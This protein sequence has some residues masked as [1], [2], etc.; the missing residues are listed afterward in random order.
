M[1]Q[2]LEFLITPLLSSPENLVIDINPGNILISVSE[3]DAGKIIGK[4]GSV[5]N[6][7][8][9]LLKAYCINHK[10]TFHNLNLNSPKKD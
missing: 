10:L 1:K 5:I 8:R 4:K 9:V 6:A 2:F 7:L 3:S